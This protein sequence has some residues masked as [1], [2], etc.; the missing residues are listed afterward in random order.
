MPPCNHDGRI[1]ALPRNEDPLVYLQP[2]NLKENMC[3][4]QSLLC[5]PPFFLL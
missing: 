2:A 3:V 5:P 4:V 1:P